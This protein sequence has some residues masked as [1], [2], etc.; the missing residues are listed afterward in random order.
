MGGPGGRNEEVGGTLE[1]PARGRGGGKSLKGV[2]AKV[3]T[4]IRS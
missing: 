4:S 1:A 2:P 3:L